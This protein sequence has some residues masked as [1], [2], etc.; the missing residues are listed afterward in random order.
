MQFTWY[1]V[2][3]IFMTLKKEII[4]DIEHVTVAVT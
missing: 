4:V 1:I 3:L 2:K